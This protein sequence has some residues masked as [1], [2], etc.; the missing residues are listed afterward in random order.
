MALPDYYHLLELPATATQSEIK[1]SY[2]RLARRYH[3][4]LNPEAL[5]RRIKLLNEA[6]KV[7]SNSVSRAAYDEQC[8]LL[9]EEAAQRRQQ[10]EK[11]Q[12]RQ[13]QEAAR[14]HQQQIEAKR[15]PKM[16]WVEGI[17]GFV[18]ELKKGLRD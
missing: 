13:Q 18:R 16:T 7:L 8:R 4:D 1:R 17:F 11:A 5:D 2:R 6:Y 9:R 3:P 12:Q 15:E 14:R 10:Q